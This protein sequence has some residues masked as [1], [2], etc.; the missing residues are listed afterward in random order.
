MAQHNDGLPAKVA[1]QILRRILLRELLPGAVLPS[2]RELQET[3]AVSRPVARE[4]IKLLA[5]RGIVDVHPRQGATIGMDLT[6]AASDALLLAFHQENVIKEDLLNARMALE[7]WIVR[8]A[9]E[10]LVVSLVRKLQQMILQ[11]EMLIALD[12]ELLNTTLSTLPTIDAE[13]H[14]LLAEMSQNP[15]FKILVDVLVG[16]LWSQTQFISPL[17]ETPKMHAKY[18][19]QAFRQ[20]VA[21]AK[22][23]LAANADLAAQ[24]MTEHLVSTYK[25]ITAGS[26]NIL[27]QRVQITI[28][29]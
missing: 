27:Q 13:F 3:Y 24:A 5:A 11:F 14:I 28:P 9:C 12:D 21:I 10:H 17:D 6:A 15:V 16:I 2:E 26:G 8:L 4:A 20:H 18:M 29:T 25:H 22:A 1:Q 23:I 19:R 7:P